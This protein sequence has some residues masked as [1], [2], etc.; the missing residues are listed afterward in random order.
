M[1]RDFTSERSKRSGEPR[2]WRLLGLRGGMAGLV[3]AGGIVAFALLRGGPAPAPANAAAP[4]TIHV[5]LDG[6][7]YIDEGDTLPR[8]QYADGSVTLNDRCM[9]KKNKLNLRLPPVFV[10]GHPIGFC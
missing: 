4:E 2:R 6:A 1:N 8:I 10:N 3:A 5:A 9:V 7:H